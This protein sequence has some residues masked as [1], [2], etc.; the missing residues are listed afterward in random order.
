MCLKIIDRSEIPVDIARLGQILLAEDDPYRLIGDRLSDLIGDEDFAELYETTG[1]AAISPMLLALVTVFQ[2]MEKLPDRA[3]ALAVV[4]RI[5]WKYA[6]HLPLEWEGFHFT[7]LNHFRQRLL[8]HDAEYLVFDKLVHKLVEL[9][10]IRRRGPQRTDSSKLLGE[11]A[12]LSRLEMV[13]E[14][15]RVTVKALLAEDKGWAEATLPESFREQ[16]QEKQ[17]SYKFSKEK[18]AESLCQAGA[19]GFWLLQQV[20]KGSAAL[21]ALPEVV[22]M[23]TVWEQQFELDKEAQYRGPR[24]KVDPHGL[25]QSPHEPEVRYRQKRGKGWQGYVAQVTETA[26]EKGEANFITDVEVTDAQVS[27]VNALPEIQ[28]RLSE[29][30]VPPKEQYVDHAYV[31][32]TR[33]AES[34]QAGIDLIGP[35]SQESGP[36]EFKLSDFTVDVEQRQ[37]ICPA[38]NAATRWTVRTR[39]DGSK[40]YVAHYEGQCATCS[41]RAKC[42]EAVAGRTLTIHEHHDFVVA[43]RAEMETAEFWHKMKRRPPVEGTISQLMRMGARRARYRGRRKVNLQLIFTATALNLK[44]LLRAWAQGQKPCWKPAAG[45]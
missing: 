38:G 23:R 16:Y 45:A 27:D 34:A 12:K 19:D 25:I 1:G 5:D 10:F 20:A 14:T 13:W 40:E 7:N 15:M 9:G 4:M 17:R 29:R 42:T 26:E 33:L 39:R 35:V 18:V 43:R 21:Q 36:C 24:A 30:D 44:R 31:S 2:M 3:A 8:E 32:G 6:L 41:L 22:T 28:E 37:A 11:V